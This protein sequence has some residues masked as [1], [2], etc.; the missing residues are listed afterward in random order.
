M[1]TKDFSDEARLQMLNEGDPLHPWTSCDELRQCAVCD[2]IFSGRQVRR[3]RSGFGFGP[4][5]CP[6]RGCTGGPSSWVL[7]GDPLVSDEA[8]A[9]WERLIEHT[10][11][12]EAGVHF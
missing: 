2:R 11:H 3:R 6:T 5:R 8:W 12:A 4:L 10:E 1:N 7:P 9:E